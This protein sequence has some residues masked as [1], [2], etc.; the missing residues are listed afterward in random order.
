MLR[1]AS[2]DF[3]VYISYGLPGLEVIKRVFTFQL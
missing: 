2:F 3:R 1:V